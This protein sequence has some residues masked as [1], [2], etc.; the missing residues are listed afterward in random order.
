MADPHVVLLGRATIYRN[1]KRVGW[2]ASGGWGYT[3]GASLGY[4][5]V[6]DPERGVTPEHVLSGSYELEVATERVTAE[7]FLAAPYDPSG[8]RI[9]A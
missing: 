3:D 5:Y 2:P 1:G 7:A 8:V 6:R 4:G 9:G